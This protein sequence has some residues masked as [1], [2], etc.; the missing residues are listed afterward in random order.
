[1]LNLRPGEEAAIC[2]PAEGD[3]VAV[4]GSSRKLLVFPLDQVPEMAR[5]AGVILQKYTGDGTLSDAARVPP[6]RRADLAQGERTRTETDLRH[7]L[8]ERAQVGRSPPHGFP[9]SGKFG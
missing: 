4:I 3:H 6:G 5:G 9:K 1:M 2:A 7:W 8:G